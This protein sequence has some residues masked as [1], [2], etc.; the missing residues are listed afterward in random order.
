MPICRPE[1]EFRVTRCADVDVPGGAALG[2]GLHA[3]AGNH[4]R[5]AAF[6]SFGQPKD[7]AQHPYGIALGARQCAK[8]DM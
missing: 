4:L 2:G 8:A 5:V 1:L 3:Q 6:E 7:R